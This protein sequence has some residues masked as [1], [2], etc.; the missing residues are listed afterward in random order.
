MSTSDTTQKRSNKRQLS[1]SVVRKSGSKTVCVEIVRVVAHPLYGKRMNRTN[2]YL[3][4]DESDAVAVGDTVL[5]E[6]SRPLSK[7]K[8][9]VVINKTV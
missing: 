1:G 3:A 4:H 2:R 7:R 8:R 9:W 6:E 5:I